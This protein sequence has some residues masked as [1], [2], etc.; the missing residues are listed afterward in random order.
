MPAVK[1]LTEAVYATG[2]V[3]SDQEYQ[4]FAQGEGV[5]TRK[6]VEVGEPVSPDQPLFMLENSQPDAR[7]QFAREAYQVAASNYRTQS[8]VLKEALAGLQAAKTKRSY[9]SLNFARYQ[10]LW[11]HQATSRAEFD[12][13][14]LA[15]DNSKTEFQAQ[16][17]RYHKLRN[18]LYLDRQHA[19]SNLKVARQEQKHYTIKS[20]LQ[21]TLLQLLKE[22]GE[23][24]K[25]GEPLA[26]IG[27]LNQFYLRLKIDELDVQR[28]KTGQEI[29]VKIDA[30]PNQLFKA[31]VAKIYPVVD[32]RDQSLRVDATLTDSLPGYYSG[33]ALEA[34]II[35]RQKEQAL[36]IP[37]TY[38]LPGD[39]VIISHDGNSRKV[40]V[41]KGVETLSEVEILAGLT[42]NTK[43]LQP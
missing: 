3:V 14:K 25:K 17:S 10:V 24:V 34:N 36:V 12:K 21:G 42:T 2:Y 33:L 6:L 28:V 5:L 39:S 30:F 9:D 29:L 22:P 8:P 43:L 41:S 35:I 31:R 20:Q 23:L 26:V 1:P 40:K 7:Y 18:Q 37:R 27:R 11:Q 13:F 38:L 19:Q 4:V 32:P 15:Y 16:L